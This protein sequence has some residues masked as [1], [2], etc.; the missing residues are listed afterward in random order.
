MIWVLD[1]VNR[2]G[3]GGKG[4]AGP[5]P[6]V[7]RDGLLGSGNR[8]PPQG[9]ARIGRPT[10]NYPPSRPLIKVGESTV[11]SVKLVVVRLFSY[12]IFG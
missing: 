2:A 11:L 12:A 5:R 10:D 1:I 7:E 8:P 9:H 3:P 6:W 4:D